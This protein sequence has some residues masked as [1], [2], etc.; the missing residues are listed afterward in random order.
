MSAVSARREVRLLGELAAE[1]AEPRGVL[2]G[3]QR[4]EMRLLM[5]LI[6]SGVAA[7]LHE[8]T[9]PVASLVGE[10]GSGA[11]GLSQLEELGSLTGRGE[12]G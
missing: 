9:L 7:G 12:P 2:L 6:V 1:A 3:L 10:A 5:L 8:A 4:H 11:T